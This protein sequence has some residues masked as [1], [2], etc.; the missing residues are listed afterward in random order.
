M[1]DATTKGAQLD[2]ERQRLTVQER[3]AGMQLEAKAAADE[4]NIN[5][6][7]HLEGARLGVDIAKNRA[8]HARRQT[9]VQ[10]KG[11]QKEPK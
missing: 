10:T 8:E 1:D 11:T 5:A 2:P 7:H 9:E 4:A 6:K 3:I